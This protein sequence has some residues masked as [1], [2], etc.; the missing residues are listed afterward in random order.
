[1]RPPNQDMRE[2]GGG[3]RNKNQH[4]N[5]RDNGLYRTNNA[6]SIGIQQK[7]KLMNL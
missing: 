7:I 3:G 2:W 5:N 1:M 6:N 4:R